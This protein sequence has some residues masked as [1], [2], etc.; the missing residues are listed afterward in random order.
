MSFTVLAAA[1]LL[2]S[3]LS[4]RADE[5]DVARGEYLVS[6]SGCNDCHTPGY[7]FGSADPERFL[8]G[9]DVGFEIP[10]LG[11]FVGRNL[12]PDKETGIGDWTTEQ[13]VTA[14][15]T[16]ERPDGRMLAPIMPYHA[17]A[18]LTPE[19]ANAIAEYLKT[20]EPVKNAVPGP[21]GPGEEVSTFMLRLVPPGAIAAEAP[22]Q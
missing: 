1:G 16:G 8:G 6:F 7:F 15:Q 10:G 22:P 11:V 9:S 14:L 21:F 19:D 12:T 4:S 18:N 3:P 17:L 20:I 5:A 2:A 13:I